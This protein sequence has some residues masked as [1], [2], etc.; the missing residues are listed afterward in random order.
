MQPFSTF[1]ASILRLTRIKLSLSV[2]VSSL[3]GYVYGKGVLDYKGLMVFIGVFLLSG[4]ASVINQIQ[5]Q[6]F[7]ALMQRT[8]NRPIPMKILSASQSWFIA[9]LLFGFS[10]PLLYFYSTL[11]GLLLGVFSLLWYVSVYTYLK[12]VSSMAM[13]PGTLTG[14][15]PVFIGWVASGQDICSHYIILAGLFMAFWQLPHFVLLMLRYEEDY[16]KA[17]FPVITRIMTIKVIGLLKLGC[18]I[19]LVIIYSLMLYFNQFNDL[20]TVI[21]GTISTLGVLGYFLFNYISGSPRYKTEFIVINIYMMMFL[22]LLAVDK[23]V[24]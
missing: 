3:A 4:A 21:P 1:I 6:K 24:K 5:E 8:T 11:S 22:L 18:V 2:G 9:L 13:I 15:I 7:D 23:L 16:K 17:G 12:R 19:V 14:I 20:L 10:L